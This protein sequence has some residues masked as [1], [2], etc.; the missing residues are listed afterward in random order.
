MMSTQR[1]LT[2]TA[3]FTLEVHL[4]MWICEGCPLL[5][6]FVALYKSSGFMPAVSVNFSLS[7]QSCRSLLCPSLQTCIHGEGEDPLVCTQSPQKDL[8]QHSWSLDEALDCSVGD[9][10]AI[11]VP[12][13]FFSLSDLHFPWSTMCWLWLLD[14]VLL[15]RSLLYCRRLR[16]K[17][18]K[19]ILEQKL[20]P[21]LSRHN[22]CSWQRL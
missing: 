7:T 18:S 4:Y 13:V 1:Q 9:R 14:L 5:F 19:L 3:L 16:Q 22:Q 11:F 17:I 21:L 6:V 12:F 10:D 2:V 20:L 15:P 8:Y